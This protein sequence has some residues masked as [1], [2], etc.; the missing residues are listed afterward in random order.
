MWDC[1]YLHG[2]DRNLVKL[3][4]TQFGVG[5]PIG[6]NVREAINEIG[7]NILPSFK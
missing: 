3:G 1:G 4:V 6:P 2:E 7:Q 5:S